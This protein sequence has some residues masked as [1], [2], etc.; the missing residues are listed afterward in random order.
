MSEKN[1]F[2]FANDEF[3]NDDYLLDDESNDDYKEPLVGLSEE[4]NKKQKARNKKI[5][6]SIYVYSVVT[7]ILLIFGLLW[8]WKFDLMAINNTIWFTIIIEFAIG[9]GMY[10]YNKNIFSPLIHG[11][12]TFGLM[13]VGKRPKKKYYDYMKDI[14]DNPVDKLFYKIIFWGCLILLIPAIITLIILL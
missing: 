12:K 5:R 3:E 10:V 2:S 4:K 11:T 1:K 8:Q 6:I 13:L 7:L 9:W 14:Q